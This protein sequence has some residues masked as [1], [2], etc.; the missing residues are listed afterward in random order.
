MLKYVIMPELSPILGLCINVIVQILLNITTKMSLLR[1]V[2][3]G[4]FCGQTAFMF[5]AL[6]ELKISWF[7]VANIAYIAAS[8][9]YFGFVNLSAT[10]LRIR[11]LEELSE[12]GGR[13]SVTKL[14]ER[15]GGQAVFAARIQRLLQSKL[16]ILRGNSLHVGKKYP[17]YAAKLLD[18]LR[19]L[20]L[21]R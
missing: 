3:L 18:A 11:I 12:A 13:L 5:I 14:L 21:G 17:L 6:P 10:S 1:T 20:I 9:C 4:F 8:F 2:L 19:S 16:L 15:Y 7:I